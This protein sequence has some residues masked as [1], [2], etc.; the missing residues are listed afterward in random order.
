MTF[1]EYEKAW[2]ERKRMLK[3]EQVEDHAFN[4][5]YSNPKV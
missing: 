5:F 3:K 2:N 1:E 4:K